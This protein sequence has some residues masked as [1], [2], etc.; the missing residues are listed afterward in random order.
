MN[1]KEK[2]KI[3]KLAN[4]LAI[5]ANQGDIESREELFKLI[6]SSPYLAKWFKRQKDK[7]FKKGSEIKSTKSR[8]YKKLKKNKTNQGC[9]GSIMQGLSGVTSAANWKYTK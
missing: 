1:S 2:T 4:S 7:V 9:K 5:K 8:R 6:Q 3:L